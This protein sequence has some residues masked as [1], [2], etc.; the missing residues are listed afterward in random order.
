MTEKKKAMFMKMQTK[1]VKEKKLS[2]G[3]E[4]FSR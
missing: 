2:K 3:I 1:I 4:G